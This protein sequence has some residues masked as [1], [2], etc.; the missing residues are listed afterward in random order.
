MNYVTV[1]KC[2]FYRDVDITLYDLFEFMEENDSRLLFYNKHKDDIEVV[3]NFDRVP[4]ETYLCNFTAE[5][6]TIERGYGRKG[7]FAFVMS[8]ELLMEYQLSYNNLVH[9]EGNKWK[10]I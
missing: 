9:I 3:I 2:T 8:D 5:T 7:E 4:T 1:S 10:L 6:E